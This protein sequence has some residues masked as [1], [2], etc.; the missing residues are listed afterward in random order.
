MTCG[1]R[2]GEWL[3][4]TRPGSTVTCA[5]SCARGSHKS[6]SVAMELPA[7]AYMLRLPAVVSQL[8][9]HMHPRL[10]PYFHPC[11]MF[12]IVVPDGSLSKPARNVC[13]GGYPGRTQSFLFNTCQLARSLLKRCVSAL[14]VLAPNGQH[15]LSAPLARGWP[16]LR[17]ER[18]RRALPQSAA[19]R[20]SGLSRGG[21]SI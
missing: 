14:L 3:R 12:C 19:H 2:D 9:L 4:T 11:V 1:G 17:R 15:L 6:C 16:R 5:T 18:A 13:V 8:R 7:H 10:S 21:V 20:R